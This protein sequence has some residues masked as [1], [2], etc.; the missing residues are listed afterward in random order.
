MAGGYLCRWH[1]SPRRA[2][3]RR[4]WASMASLEPDPALRR[5]FEAEYRRL[6][7]LDREIAERRYDVAGR[8]RLG[9]PRTQCSVVLDAATERRCRK[10]A[11]PDTEPPICSTHAPRAEHPTPADPDD[12]PR[13]VESANPGDAASI[14]ARP[15]GHPGDRPTGDPRNPTDD[16]TSRALG[17]SR[18]DRARLARLARRDES[19]SASDDGERRAGSPAGDTAW[20]G[21]GQVIVPSTSSS[22]HDRVAIGHTSALLRD[23]FDPWGRRT[24]AATTRPEPDDPPSK[25]QAKRT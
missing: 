10:R 1:G 16:P 5:V 19:R 7:E 25:T 12:G 18:H 13:A 20:R 22:S 14:Q 6:V 4:A 17:T 21:M 3:R 2:K 8:P 15:S 24:S 9:V 11:V 23:A